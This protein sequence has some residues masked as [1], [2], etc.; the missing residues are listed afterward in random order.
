MKATDSFSKVN[1]GGSGYLIL[2]PEASGQNSTP[3]SVRVVLIW[4]PADL[5]NFTA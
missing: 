2:P 4:R 3:K 1:C 5:L